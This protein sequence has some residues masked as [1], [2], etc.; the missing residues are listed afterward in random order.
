MSQ[1]AFDNYNHLE[2]MEGY[3]TQGYSVSFSRSSG[4]TIGFGVDLSQPPYNTPEGLL[5]AGFD[6]SFVDNVVSLDILGKDVGIS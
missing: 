3:R 2:Q 1:K 5:N 6:Q 4:I